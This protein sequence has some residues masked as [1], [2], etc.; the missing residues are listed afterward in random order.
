MADAVEHVTIPAN[1]IRLHCARTGAGPLILFLHGFPEYWEA[2]RGQLA[3]FGAR[4][5][6]A[7]APD[8]RGYGLSDKPAEVAQY[9]MRHLVEDVRQLAAALTAEP[10]VLVAH[11]WGGG[12]AWALAQAHPRL[13]SHLV[14]LNSPHP[15]T[16]WRELVRS[17]AQQAAS[18]YMLRLRAP[19]AERV[20]S[21]DG[22]RRLWDLAFGGGWGPGATGPDRA[23]YVEAWSRPGALT[24]ALAWYRASPLYP[25]S[26]GDPGAAALALRAEDFVVRVRT[27][28]LWGERDAALLPGCLDGLEQCVPDLEVRRV[29]DASHWIVHE[30]PDLVNAEIERFI[31]TG[32]TP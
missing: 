15:Y 6:L 23:R 14:I 10:F 27:L 21:E 20:L 18:R 9:R 16:F 25:P 13:V 31:T 22:H 4:G 24:G 2:W 30:R 7:A 8:L 1:G 28:V 3:F 29:P 11:D 5:R 32:G 17:P 26:P 19:D 12:V